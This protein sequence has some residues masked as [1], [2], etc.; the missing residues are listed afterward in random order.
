MRIRKVT[1]MRAW[2]AVLAA[3]KG[4]SKVSGIIALVWV[5]WVDSQHWLKERERDLQRYWEGTRKVGRKRR[6]GENRASIGDTKTVRVKRARAFDL[7]VEFKPSPT[8]PKACVLN[9]FSLVSRD[10]DIRIDSLH[11]N[12]HPFFHLF[13]LKDHRKNI[14]STNLTG[15]TFDM[16]KPWFPEPENNQRIKKGSSALCE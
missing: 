14:F 15:V 16:A 2:G 1:H 13:K 8:C 5:S 3:W 7:K 11:K 9:F 10:V 6:K 4:A 12:M